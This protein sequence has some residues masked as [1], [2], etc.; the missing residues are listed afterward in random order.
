MEAVLERRSYIV[1]RSAT[2]AETISICQ[3]K[4]APIDLV[5]VE[6]P[7]AGSDSNAEAALQ[8]RRSCPEMPLLLVSDTP[9]EGWSEADF[10][11]FE[12]LLPVRIDLLCKPLS[13]GSFIAKANSLLY[14]VSYLDSRK[15]FNAAAGIRTLTGNGR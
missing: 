14:T 15:L 7:L 5:I 10:R 11:C 8:I 4:S 9:L 3:N 1:Y 13:Q 2:V 6:A 12:N